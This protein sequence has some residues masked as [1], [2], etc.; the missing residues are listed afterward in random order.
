MSKSKLDLDFFKK[1][2]YMLVSSVNSVNFKS[3]NSDTKKVIPSITK[4]KDL[5]SS[6]FNPNTLE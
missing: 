2:V 4:A 1:E 6:I 3:G 5:T